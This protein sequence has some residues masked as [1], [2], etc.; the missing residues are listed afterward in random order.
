MKDSRER[1]ISWSEASSVFTCPK[2]TEYSYDAGLRP[3][4]AAPAL[5][6]GSAIHEAIAHMLIDNSWS[7]DC[8]AEAKQAFAKIFHDA[9]EKGM[10]GQ[11]RY[12]LEDME[13]MGQIHLEQFHEWAKNQKLKTLGVELY[14]TRRINDDLVY[15]GTLDWVYMTRRWGVTEIVVVDHKT[16]AREYTDAFIANDGQL[17]GYQFLLEG[18]GAC[19]QIPELAEAKTKVMVGYSQFVKRKPGGRKG[20]EYIPPKPVARSTEQIEEFVSFVKAAQEI[21]KLPGFRFAGHG[22][23]A[24]CDMCDFRELCITGE[25]PEN[26]VV[27]QRKAA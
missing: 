17:T 7:D 15:S 3:V 18:E 20:P 11:G 22:F 12:T 14:L 4:V 13:R 26:L 16:P 6:Y 23:A 21:R 5:E 9:R 1:R 27:K 10:Q 2:K 25:M 19:E 24:H 8:L